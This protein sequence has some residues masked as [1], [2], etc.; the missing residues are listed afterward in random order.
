VA[1]LDHRQSTSI[2]PAIGM[3]TLD[4]VDIV[5]S[6]ESVPATVRTS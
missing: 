1:V 3:N 5:G 2:E 4:E 6:V